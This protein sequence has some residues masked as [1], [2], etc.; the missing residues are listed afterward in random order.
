MRRRCTSTVL[1]MTSDSAPLLLLMKLI[2]PSIS[3]HSLLGPADTI[4]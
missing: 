1:P 2:P 3:S 4:G